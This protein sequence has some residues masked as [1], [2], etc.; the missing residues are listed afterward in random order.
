MGFP[1]ADT[2]EWALPSLMSLIFSPEK[3]SGEKKRGKK[4]FSFS[5]FIW[6]WYVKHKIKTKRSSIIEYLHISLGFLALWPPSGKCHP[7]SRC[8]PISQSGRFQ[9]VRSRIPPRID[10]CDRLKDCKKNLTHSVNNSLKYRARASWEI[11]NHHHRR[12]SPWRE[13]S[14]FVACARSSPQREKAV[15]CPP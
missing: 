9:L 7:G 15:S 2:S 4:Y 13:I 1:M 12:P 3:W 14:G 6:W 11:F 10:F 5:A 8:G